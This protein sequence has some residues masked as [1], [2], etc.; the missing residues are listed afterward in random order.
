MKLE[1]LTIKKFAEGLRKK[2]FFAEEVT[3]AYLDRIEKYDGEIGAYLHVMND[4]ALAQAKIVDGKIAKGEELGAL[5]GVPL[6]IKDNML[7]TGVPATAGSK[8]LE[9]HVG[10]YDATVI[11]K[12]KEEGAV[13][14]GKTNMDEFAMG[15]ST[16]NSAYQKTKN[17]RDLSRV[18]GGSSGGSAAAVAGD[19]AMGAFGSDTGGSIRQPA[20]FCGVVGLKPTYGAVSRY[21][22]IAMASSL[23]QIGPFAKTVEDAAMLFRATAGYDKFDATSVNLPYDDEVTHV[24]EREVKQMTVGLPKEYFID[25]LEPEVKS[26]MDNVIATIKG[27]GV[28]VKEISLPHTAHALSCYY[29]IMPA[30]VSSNLARFD[31]IRYAKVASVERGSHNLAELYKKNRHTGFGAEVKRRIMLGTFVLSSGYYDAYYSQAQ[32]VRAMIK[33][34]FDE[35]FR[36]VDM[37]LTPVSPTRPFKFGEKANDP[38]AMY[39]SDIFTIPANLAGVPAISIPVRSAKSASSPRESA[40]LP[41]G[42]QLIGKHFRE[43]DILSL[44]RMYEAA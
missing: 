6:A 39:L 11:K 19:M 10:V 24:H 2:E 20:G 40:S 43:E 33:N 9:H 34:D 14:L 4:A 44:G 25:G 27:L 7:I 8:M 36:D 42:F 22:L 3:Q 41:I 31:G 18:P 13:F 23:D 1:D 5:A 29:I 12:L 21:G 37:I 26:A 32:K 28:K 17:P 15:S 38:L 30:E 16:E 35:A